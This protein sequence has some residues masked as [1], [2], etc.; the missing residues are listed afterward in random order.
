MRTATCIF[1]GTFCS[2]WESPRGGRTRVAGWDTCACKCHEMRNYMYGALASANSMAMVVLGRC[3]SCT[4]PRG[5]V[6]H[7][8]QPP[9]GGERADRWRALGPIRNEINER[10]CLRARRGGATKRGGTRG[11]QCARRCQARLRVG[12]VRGCEPAAPACAMVV[13]TLRPG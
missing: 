5:V 8:I 11:V 3:W 2:I 4:S 9:R 6:Q 12:R 1:I 7:G 10:L 13:T